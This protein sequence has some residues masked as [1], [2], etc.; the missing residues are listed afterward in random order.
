MHLYF[1]VSLMREKDVLKQFSGDY[2]GLI[3]EAHSLE[4]YSNSIL[5][6]LNEVRNPFIIDPVT[7]KF[8][9]PI[10]I[11]Q[12]DKRWFE[13]LVDA[14]NLP[15]D[16]TSPIVVPRLLSNGILRRHVESVVNYQRNMANRLQNTLQNVG[17][18]LLWMSEEA[19]LFA[20][21]DFS[22]EYIVSPYFIIE[23]VN[24][25]S[26]REWLDLN[27]KSI[28]I[29]KDILSG[30]EK[31]LATIAL[32]EEAFLSDEVLNYVLQTYSNLSVD[33]Y[34]LWIANFDEITQAPEIL[35]RFITFI[36]KL[37]EASKV[38]LVNL[39]GGYFSLLLSNEDKKLLDG[40]TQGLTV[41]EHRDPFLH[42][43]FAVPRYYLPALHLFISHED[44]GLLSSI[45]KLRC[46]C[47]VCS[48]LG[49]FE[50]FINIS[51]T[52]T[53]IHFIHNRITEAKQVEEKRLNELL[54]SL[55]QTHA[56][57]E[58]LQRRSGKKLV[59]YSHLKYWVDAL[60]E[61]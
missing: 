57:M 9:L 60:K 22:P 16:A 27:R 7:Y 55:D 23:D 52:D 17:G 48:K 35:R 59:Y 30:N 11:E 33:A 41:A 31:L 46:Q 6:F 25:T 47:P 26:Y 34:A 38:P 61:N 42:G 5:N 14:Y 40:V 2:H 19:E 56:F 54:E 1:R 58:N 49:G 15:V 12:T 37:K 43:G 50:D 8:A 29:T 51:V 10:I 3:L 32:G 21:S 39:Y 18:L 36:E 45:Q 24:H 13:R 53:M 28:E 20:R 4:L 44:A